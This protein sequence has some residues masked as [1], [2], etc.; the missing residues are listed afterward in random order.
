ML[1]QFFYKSWA[2]YIVTVKENTSKTEST[3]K[4][5]KDGSITDIINI[6]LVKVKD[7]NMNKET[8]DIC[9]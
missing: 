6:L 8:K 2:E 9:H 4:R 3:L 7:T 5:N 1:Y